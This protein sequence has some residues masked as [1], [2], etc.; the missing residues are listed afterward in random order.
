[1]ESIQN[2]NIYNCLLSY[3]KK[4]ELT[5]WIKSSER[6]TKKLFKII[7]NATGKQQNNAIPEGKSYDTLA[8]EFAN[9][10]LEKIEKIRQQFININLFKPKPTDT[11]RL[12]T[13]APLTTEEVKK[14]NF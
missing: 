7:N 8:E 4:Q 2:R 1:M 6:D 10:F 13:C 3:N 9:Y 14:G 12:Q 11:Y 5:C